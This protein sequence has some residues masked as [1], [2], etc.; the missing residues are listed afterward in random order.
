[1]TDRDGFSSDDL[2]KKAREE[3]R[4]GERESQSSEPAASRSEARTPSRPPPMPHDMERA[5]FEE[6]LIDGG[7]SLESDPSPF[8]FERDEA[9]DEIEP[10]SRPSPITSAGRR[11]GLSLAIAAVIV[12]IGA[13]IVVGGVLE[14]SSTDADSFGVG[15]CFDDPGDTVVSDIATVDCGSPHDFEMIGS[16]KLQS[17]EYPGEDEI[18]SA[19]IGECTDLFEDYVGAPYATS[20]W[21]LHA[22]TPTSEGWELGDRVA[23]CLVFQFDT[24]D[25][26]LAVTGTAQGDGR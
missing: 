12:G 10:T 7:I 26:I 23:N 13:A 24:D 22:F 5:D 11:T 17:E 6:T 21:Y 1:M 8:G 15:S 18:W 14:D 4:A 16:V 19:A 25:S 9:S 2:I 3:A 20:I